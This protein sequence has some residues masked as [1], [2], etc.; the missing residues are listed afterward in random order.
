MRKILISCLT[1]V[2]KRGTRAG[3]ISK[4]C[5]NSGFHS[6]PQTVQNLEVKYYQK[7]LWHTLIHQKECTLVSHLQ[8]ISRK[9]TT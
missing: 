5:R 2:Y 8:G 4:K 3:V 1:G 9:V 6:A 7:Y